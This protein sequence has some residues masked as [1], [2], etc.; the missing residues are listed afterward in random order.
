MS[1]DNFGTIESP[2]S[3]ESR[4]LYDGATA[5][6]AMSW[7]AI[8]FAFPWRVR[9][10]TAS[11]ARARALLVGD[12]VTLIDSEGGTDSVDAYVVDVDRGIDS[13][14]LTLTIIHKP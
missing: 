11:T 3:L 8:A 12:V 5:A 9:T 13:A 14:T 10:V 1:A 2:E 6:R 4:M 7:R